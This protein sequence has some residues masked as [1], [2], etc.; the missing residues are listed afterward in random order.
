MKITAILITAGML[1]S[2][3]FITGCTD[4]NQA[5]KKPVEVCHKEDYVKAG[6]A[7]I[8]AR[9]WFFTCGGTKCIVSTETKRKGK[10]YKRNVKMKSPQ[11]FY[12]AKAVDSWDTDHC[13]TI[14]RKRAK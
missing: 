6:K 11:E 4:T 8:A 13:G 9:G 12:V 1:A 10:V 5:D 3:V 14:Y 2:F 7:A